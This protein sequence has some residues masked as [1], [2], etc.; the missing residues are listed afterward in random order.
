MEETLRNRFIHIHQ[1]Q[2]VDW[3]VFYRLLSYD[4]SLTSFYHMSK[5][6]LLPFFNNNP[7]RVYSFY[8]D[9]HSQSI[10]DILENYRENKINPIS[11]VDDDYPNTLKEI[12]DPPWVIYTIGKS[13]W[14]HCNR[15]ISVVGTRAPSR[16]GVD[17]IKK[18]IE[19]L[20]QQKWIIVSGLAVGVDTLSH[21]I[22]VKNS[23]NT[24]AVLGSGFFHIYPSKNRELARELAIN[25][26]LITEYPPNVKPQKWH[27]PRRNR[28]ISGLSRGTIVIEAKQK[29]GSLITAY[30]ALEQGKEVF[31]VPGSIFGDNSVGTNQLIKEGA[32]PVMQAGDIFEIIS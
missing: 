32:H 18:L 24:V 26:L 9:L 4:S 21:M 30:Q 22:A 29:S 5:R 1:C 15:L 20:V 10:S 16:Y 14:L 19:P 25:H 28:I 13:N 7:Q 23:G 2:S 8:K 3:K 12:Y 11:F 6:E 27:F 17:C 31:A